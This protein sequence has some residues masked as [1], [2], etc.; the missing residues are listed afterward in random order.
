MFISDD[1]EYV[2]DGVFFRLFFGNTLDEMMKFTKCLSG[3]P[4]STRNRDI[5][6]TRI[7]EDIYICTFV[8]VER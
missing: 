4:F 7:N 6:H 8:S 2:M 1:L 5:C 3:Q